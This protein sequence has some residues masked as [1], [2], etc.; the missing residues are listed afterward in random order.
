MPPMNKIL[1]LV[2]GINGAKHSELH[3]VKTP[4][5]DGHGQ[6]LLQTKL[7]ECLSL[8]AARLKAQGGYLSSG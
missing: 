1:S 4:H 2:S 3:L 8:Q 7:A 6:S 5:T